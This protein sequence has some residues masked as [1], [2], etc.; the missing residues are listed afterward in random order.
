MILKRVT[1]V[2][3]KGEYMR[4]VIHYLQVTD[5]F[6][7]LLHANYPWIERKFPLT[8]PIFLD[9]ASHQYH[10]RASVLHP[11]SELSCSL[12]YSF[13]TVNS[14][15]D[16]CIYILNWWLRS[17]ALTHKNTAFCWTSESFCAAWLQGLCD[18]FFYILH[19]FYI[20]YSSIF[21]I[22]F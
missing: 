10:A 13:S 1:R 3:H 4:R 7:S 5:S 6:W 11:Q 9:F 21:F 17:A 15:C 12:I 22:F 14:L 18:L 20:L 8:T 16:K 2:I 19:I